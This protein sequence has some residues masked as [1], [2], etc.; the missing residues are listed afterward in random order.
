MKFT[1]MLI[2]SQENKL[3]EKFYKKL[4]FEVA[5]STPD[6]SEV[7]L[8]DF[9]IVIVNMRDVDEYNGGSL[10]GDK[11]RGIYAIILVCLV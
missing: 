6:Y 4:G 10:S 3:S 11:V 5:T 8:G 2:W 7:K 9:E 1:N